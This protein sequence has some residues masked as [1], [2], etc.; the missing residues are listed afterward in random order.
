LLNE[1]MSPG[2]HEVT[3]NAENLSSG[4]YFY[5]IE[6]SDFRQSRKMLLVK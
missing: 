1:V 4:V 5:E 3:F 2:I 6:T